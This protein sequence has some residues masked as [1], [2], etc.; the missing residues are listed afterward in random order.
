MHDAGRSLSLGVPPCNYNLY[1]FRYL[2]VF[3]LS[4]AQQG[5]AV[6]TVKGYLSAISAFLQ[7]PDQLFKLSVMM[8][9]LKGLIHVSTQTICDATVGP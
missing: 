1:K 3:E 7:L 6:A 2:V 4:L 9:F 5:L 8:R